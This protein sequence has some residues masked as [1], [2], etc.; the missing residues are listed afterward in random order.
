MAGGSRRV[1]RRLTWP[2]LLVAV[3]LGLVGGWTAPAVAHAQLLSTAPAAGAVLTSPPPDVVLHFGEAVELQLGSIQVFNGDGKR[4]DT[5]ACHHVPGQSNTAEVTLPAT[6]AAGGYV[7][8]WRVISADSHPVHG[9]FTFQVGSGAASGQLRSEAAGLLA[10]SGTNRT[11]GI[12]FGAARF[13]EFA[14]LFVLI[15][16][17]FFVLAVWPAGAGEP[18]A[19]ALIWGAL[20]L[21]VAAATGEFLLQGPYGAGLSVG[22]AFNSQVL[23]AVWHSRYGRLTVLR[24]AVLAIAGGVV[25]LLLRRRSRLVAAAA[26]AVGLAVLAT[27][28]LAGHAAT[29]SLVPLA[30]PFDV[31]HI[32]AAAVWFGGLTMLVVVVLTRPDEARAVTRFSQLALGAVIA[33]A[34][35]GGFAA[36]RQ[37]GT[38][39]AVTATTYGRLVLAKTIAFAGVVAV[40]GFS[41]TTV[42]GSLAVPGRSRPPTPPAN[43]WRRL[44]GAVGLEVVVVATVL[45]LAAVLINAQPAKQAF[46][47][48][49]SNEVHAGPALV[50]T[51]IDP[52]KAGPVAFH[53]YVLTADGAQL[54]VPEVIATMSQASN[55]INGLGVP[56]A[57]A[58]T[59]HFVAYGFEVPIRGTWTVQI[60]VRTTAIDEYSATPFTVHIR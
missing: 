22:H 59:G 15:G 14:G 55:G 41:R 30:L 35:T 23:S 13:L 40:A 42:H 31:V 11:V 52:A 26:G 16:A 6:L 3:A 25:V 17:V 12:A 10:K 18:R 8:T 54:D 49:F 56:L 45:G 1:T 4:I 50:D 33:I 60:K 38:L 19:R 36:W 5:G 2:V 28:S 37:I 27:I 51:T 47:Q 39:P 29:G 34:V 21:S 7:V 32:G 46:A 48:P 53:V 44:R 9:A 57:R 20:A 43:G 58:G 24:V